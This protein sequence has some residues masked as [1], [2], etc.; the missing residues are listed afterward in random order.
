MTFAKRLKNKKINL[1]FKTKTYISKILHP[2]K[3]DCTKRGKTPKEVRD[4]TYMKK[5]FLQR[6]M[7]SH[8]KVY[9]TAKVTL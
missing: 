2:K 9:V 5:I 1:H 4:D 7:I 8:T 3:N 6:I